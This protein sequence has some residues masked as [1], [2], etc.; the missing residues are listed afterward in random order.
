MEV[1]GQLLTNL[2]TYLLT[3]SMELSNT[4]EATHGCFTFFC[5]Y[6]P[7]KDL[8]QQNYRATTLERGI[9]HVR[10]KINGLLWELSVMETELPKE[11]IS[12]EEEEEEEEH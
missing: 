1:S 5:F 11:E 9:L 12:E 8:T 7:L 4:R 2:L 10:V 6:L 3:N